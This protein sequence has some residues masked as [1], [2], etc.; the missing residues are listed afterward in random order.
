[1]RGPR[2]TLE[3][4]RALVAVV[5]AGGYV[6]A[7]EQVH[8]TQSSITYAVQK[9]EQQLDLKLFERV[10]RRARLTPAGEAMYLRA[11][12]LIDR[13]ESVERSA[14]AL[15]QDWD[16]ELRLAVE[17]VFPTWLLL[18]SLNR[19][20]EERPA[21]RVQLY[22][23]VLGGMD[24]ALLDRRVDLAVTPH[25]PQGFGGEPLLR[26]RFI[27]AA[28]PEHPL[29]QLDRPVTL[30]DLARHRHLRI[31]DTAVERPRSSGG[32]A[33]A[34]QRWTVSNKATQIAAACSGM[35]FAWFP[36]HSIERELQAGQLKPLPLREGR[37][38]YSEVYLVF[39]EPDYPTASAVRMAEIIRQDVATLCPA[40][41]ARTGD[42]FVTLEPVIP[43]SGE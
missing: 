39:A 20:G 5:E 4:W 31:R 25:L 43:T 38:R 30:D 22:E 1:M 41:S 36:E 42:E 40:E 9:I 6:Q 33:G 27:A 3:Q 23:T 2:I 8:K 18:R 16:P 37:E 13:A 26:L 15:G 35:G 28:H 11:K 21:T 14:A 24:E 29:H 19:F 34:A 7:S 12:N 32:W 17:I 10:G